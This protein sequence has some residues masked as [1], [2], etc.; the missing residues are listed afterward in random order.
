MKNIY[1]FSTKN[2]V[3]NYWKKYI[4]PKYTVAFYTNLSTL[5]SAMEKVK[6]DIVLFDYDGHISNLEELLIYSH[7][8]EKEILVMALNSNPIFS[9]GVQLLRK[10]VRAFMNSYAKPENLNQA[11][12]AVSKGNIWLY[13]EFIQVMIK[14]SLFSDVEQSDIV[15]DLSPREREIAELIALG[16]SNKEIA[17]N[18]KITEPTVKTHL[19]TIYEKMHVHTRLELAILINRIKN[20]Y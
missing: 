13:P 12:E 18:S 7:A 6:P 2:S 15:E 5:Y 8:E 4:N 16:M 1:L 9:Q 3:I 19:K 14:Q 17:K 11:I 20:S 10:G